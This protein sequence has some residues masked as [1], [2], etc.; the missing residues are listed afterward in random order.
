VLT[1]KKLSNDAENNAAVTCASS[2]HR[3]ATKKYTSTP[4]MNIKL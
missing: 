2:N 1:E 3:L 4:D